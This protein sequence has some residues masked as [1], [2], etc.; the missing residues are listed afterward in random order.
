MGANTNPLG[1]TAWKLH[2][3]V[4]APIWYGMSSSLPEKW[5]ELLI[6]VGCQYFISPWTKTFPKDLV[7]NYT[8]KFGAQYV[9]QNMVLIG[10][11]AYWLWI[12][13]EFNN[14]ILN[15]MSETYVKIA[16]GQRTNVTNADNEIFAHDQYAT[17]NRDLMIYYR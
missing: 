7:L 16:T 14:N 6:A 11:E 1:N 10:S 5:E 15:V 2:N 9:A 12:A 13:A 17:Y 4:T 3:T 8:S